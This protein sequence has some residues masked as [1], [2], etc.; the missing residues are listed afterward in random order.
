M[1]GAT[2][3]RM[4]MGSR[5]RRSNARLGIT[6]GSTILKYSNLWLERS[7]SVQYLGANR[8]LSIDSPPPVGWGRGS[9]TPALCMEGSVE[10]WELRGAQEAQ[11]L[12]VVHPAVCQ[13]T[14]G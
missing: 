3:P 14:V 13:W 4:A 1:H 7:S 6:C 5:R 12:P 9:S 2:A 8:L 11:Q 10:Q